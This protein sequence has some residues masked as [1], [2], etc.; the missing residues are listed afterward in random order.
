MWQITL[1]LVLYEKGTESM[2]EAVQG[3]DITA[4][5]IKILLLSGGL[6]EEDSEDAL[7]CKV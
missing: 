1:M 3:G 5:K 4:Y 7:V 6:E 2:S